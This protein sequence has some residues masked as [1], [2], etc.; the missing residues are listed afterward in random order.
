MDARERLIVAFDG[1]WSLAEL[2]RIG[3][4]LSGRIGMAK[5]GKRL[6]TR[7][8]PGVIEKLVAHSL[9]VFLD[10]K[11]NDIP[12]TVA[13]AC[14][15]AVATG[16]A[17]LDVHASGGREMMLRA[18][19]SVDEAASR[20][21]VVPPILIAVTVLTSFDEG[22]LNEVGVSGPLQEQVRRLASLAAVCGLDGAVASPREIEVIRKACGPDFLIVTP[23]IRPG[24]AV[25][26]DDQKRVLSPS[27]ALE[28]G[29]DYIVVGRPIIAAPD[30]VAAA[31]EVIAEMEAPERA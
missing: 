2:D 20:L 17:M 22:S 7:H 11:F 18:R 19:E 14:A 13:E 24:G 10:L 25:M 3:A 23:G 16:A 27:A 6:F 5:I 31:R 9:P 21:G 12:N 29:A 4:E 8:G 15:E 1:D 30:P 26:G 28:K